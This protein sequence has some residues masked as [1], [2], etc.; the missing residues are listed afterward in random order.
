MNASDLLPELKDWNGGRGITPEDWLYCG[1]V[2]SELTTAIS[3]LFWPTFQAFE[4]YVLREGFSL[5]H[6]RDWERVD[7]STRK[8]VEATVN[9]LHIDD[10]F[11][12]ETWTPLVEARAARLGQILTRIYVLKLASDFP[13]RRFEVEIFD[14]SQPGGDISLSF[15]Q[16]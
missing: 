11:S 3:V 6:V 1:M 15:W 8:M 9:T 14:G 10:L 4:G 13:E 2:S 5:K 12:R 7:G 16:V